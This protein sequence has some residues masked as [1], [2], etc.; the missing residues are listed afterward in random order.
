MNDEI[1]HKDKIGKINRSNSTSGVKAVSEIDRIKAAQAI[2]GVT[3]VSGVR[4]AGNVNGISFEQ[5]DKL[6]RMVSEESAKLAAQGVIPAAQREVVEKAVQMVID[7][8]LI[9]PTDETNAKKTE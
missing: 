1:K 4:A 2:K 6:L 9:E 8:T 5:R 7:A 3:A